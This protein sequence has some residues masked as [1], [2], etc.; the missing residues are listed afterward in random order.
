[1]DDEPIEL[2]VVLPAYN[3]GA[4]VEGAV[5][6]CRGA[7]A[8]CCRGF[9]IIV[10]NDGSKDDTRAVAEK[11]AAD[12]AEVRLLNHAVNRGQVAALLTGMA[13]ARGRVVT[14]NGVDLPFDPRDTGRMLELFRRGADV[15]VVQ[16]ANREAYG[17]VRKVISWANIA[18]VKLLFRSPFV[19]H[20]FVQ[21]YRRAVFEDVVVESRGVSTVT[22]ELILKAYESGCRVERMSA[23]YHMRRTGKSSVTL[24]KIMHTM[25]E[26]LRLWTI[27]RRWRASAKS[28][29]SQPGKSPLR[30]EVSK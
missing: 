1:M 21:G 20:N 23:D 7:L 30:Q 27:M 26:L 18:L 24:R 19:D 17:P 29:S 25:G 14:H 2:T 9:E 3:E 5:N 4:A 16:R 8:E 15:V 28:R 12:H 22:A 6:E 10:V 13:Q 11:L